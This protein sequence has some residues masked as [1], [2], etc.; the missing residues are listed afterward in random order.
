M[1]NSAARRYPQR[2]TRLLAR[3]IAPEVGHRISR[4]FVHSVTL[5]DLSSVRDPA[6]VPPAV[7][8]ADGPQDPGEPAPA[9]AV[10]WLTSGN[11]R[12]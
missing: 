1:S 2:P 10:S 6:L 4:E 3:E 7:A 5:V 8:S 9:G 11:V 12:R